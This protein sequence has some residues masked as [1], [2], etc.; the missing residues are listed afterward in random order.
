MVSS[1]S[2]KHGAGCYDMGHCLQ[3]IPAWAV[4]RVIGTWTVAG[5][6]VTCECMVYEE[7]DAGGKNGSEK[8]R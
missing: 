3:G 5:V 2:G 7:S 6:V 1:G 4:M 8:A